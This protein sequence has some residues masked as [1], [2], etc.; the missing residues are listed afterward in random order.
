MHGSCLRSSPHFSPRA[1]AD[2]FASGNGATVAADVCFS[3]VMGVNSN[4]N[5]G[6]GGNGDISSQHMS[7]AQMALCDGSVRY[8]SNNTDNALLTFLCNR[9]DQTMI[10]LPQN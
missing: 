3:P 9:R 1:N 8:L 10:S 2:T 6:V 4:A 7:G 5:R